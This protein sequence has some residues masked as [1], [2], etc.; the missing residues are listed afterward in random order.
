MSEIRS[1]LQART[2]AI[3]A[4]LD[5]PDLPNAVKECVEAICAAYS[6]GGTLF[7][8]GNGGNAANAEQ[9]VTELIARYCYDRGPVA[10]VL[11]TASG[12]FTAINND[13][14]Y[15]RGF[16]RQVE[17]LAGADDLVVGFSTSGMSP[18]VLA[19]LEA[20]QSRNARTIAF[21]GAS[22]DMMNRVDIPIAVDA[23]FTPTV[24]EAH[25]I[26]IH[27]I[28]GMVEE[29]LFKDTGRRIRTPDA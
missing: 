25:L 23:K 4:S 22:G 21:C 19:G 15:E 18:N 2:Q 16:A 5:H 10:A 1:A 13:Y 29:R 24:E 3:A 12:P 28:C 20:A 6:R 26:L 8:F 27:L 9:L 11:L 14:G 17:A 7:A